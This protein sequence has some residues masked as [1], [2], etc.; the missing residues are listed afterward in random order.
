VY[1]SLWVTSLSVKS[2]DKP[3]VSLNRDSVLGGQPSI[4]SVASGVRDA[5][6]QL[7][8]WLQAYGEV[9]LFF[10]LTDF[11]YAFTFFDVFS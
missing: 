1:L 11:V 9:R 10:R 5:P 6:A 3:A 4:L 7:D 8:A 2:A